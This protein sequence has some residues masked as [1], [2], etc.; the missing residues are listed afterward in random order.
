MLTRA[1]AVPRPREGARLLAA[2]VVH[3]LLLTEETECCPPSP[4]P[5]DSPPPALLSRSLQA[6]RLAKQLEC[7]AWVLARLPRPRILF[8]CRWIWGLCLQ[9]PLAPWL[10]MVPTA[11][12]LSPGSHGP[13]EGLASKNSRGEAGGPG[14]LWPAPGSAAAP[15][16]SRPRTTTSDSGVCLDRDNELRPHFLWEL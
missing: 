7:P 11:H 3:S 1:A 16:P 10:I 4:P 12:P 13:W 6:E 9:R 2:A 8:P 14:V 15:P 5:P